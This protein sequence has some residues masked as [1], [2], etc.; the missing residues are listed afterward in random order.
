MKKISFLPLLLAAAVLTGLLSGC[1]GP[2]PAPSEP[3]ALTAPQLSETEFTFDQLGQ[4]RLLPDWEGTYAVEDPAVVRLLGNVLMA[5]GRGST[6][7][8]AG[9]R[10]I[11]VTVA[12]KA[13]VE[14][15][16]SRLVRL[17]TR[18]EPQKTLTAR[19]FLPTVFD[20]QEAGVIW[21]SSNPQAVTV[22]GDGLL[23]AVGTGVARISAASAYQITTT[24]PSPDG[25]G[26][27]TR[28]VIA[29]DVIT[30]TVN[31][32]F[33]PELHGAIP[34][35]YEGHYDWQGFSLRAS[36]EKPIYNQAHLQWIRGRVILELHEDG[37]FTQTLLNAQRADYPDAIDADLPEDTYAQ[38]IVK[39]GADSCLLYNSAPQ[40]PDDPE[41]A[42]EQR[43]FGEI[44]GMDRIGL[45]PMQEHGCYVIREGQLVLY[46]GLS[47]G[48]EDGFV[49]GPVEDM[50]FLKHPY[51]PFPGLVQVSERMTVPLEKTA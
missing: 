16:G 34:G 40:H 30:V 25:S 8:T 39:Y 37:T 45:R 36:E 14:I 18:T 4:T 27:H 49:Y 15:M 46:G 19:V 50:A 33:D 2:E 9:T 17:H 31:D 23:T 48:A 26:S 42:S 35:R 6:T 22:D 11:P 3:A 12:P 10:R 44:A 5:V 7:L 28:A 43:R 38:Q 21:A 24:Q 1:G 51:R 41:F 32:E 47:G 13:R 20:D 29:P